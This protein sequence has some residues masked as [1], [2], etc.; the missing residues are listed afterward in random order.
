MF[1]CIEL[2][3]SLNNLGIFSFHF[4]FV[5]ERTLKTVVSFFVK[6][7]SSWLTFFE[8]SCSSFGS[9]LYFVFPDDITLDE[10]DEPGLSADIAQ[11]LAANPAILDYPSLLMQRTDVFPG[12]EGSGG[13]PAEPSGSNDPAVKDAAGKPGLTLSPDGKYIIMT[14]TTS[15]HGFA[16]PLGEFEFLRTIAAAATDAAAAGGSGTSGGVS[17]IENLPEEL[18]KVMADARRNG[19]FNMEA[20]S[21]FFQVLD[22]WI[23]QRDW[24]NQ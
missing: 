2:S 5:F 20:F 9:V 3:K 22:A 12:L 17:G 21:N 23:D 7:K 4:L 8:D 1:I 6:K 19:V 14:N 18:A 16:A 15:N 11:F 24:F 13:S 10:G